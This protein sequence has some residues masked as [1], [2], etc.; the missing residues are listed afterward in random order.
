MIK[1]KIAKDKKKNVDNICNY[2][3]IGLSLLYITFSK[4][5][6]LC[7][8]RWHILS[9]SLS[10]F[11]LKSLFYFSLAL[12]I[13]PFLSISSVLPFSLPFNI[14]NKADLH[15]VF[16]LHYSICFWLCDYVTLLSNTL[17][18]YIGGS[19]YSI[20]VFLAVF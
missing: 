19:N 6:P 8:Y 13:F 14:S 1:L 12:T 18:I 10:H 7:E 11:S 5:F 15:K 3:P 2:F 16:H 4:T 9:L 17:F 20:T